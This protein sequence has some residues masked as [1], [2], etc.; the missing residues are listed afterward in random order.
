[1]GLDLTITIDDKGTPVIKSF[2]D[3][4]KDA[5]KDVEGQTKK[6]SDTIKSRWARAENAF[7]SNLGK[8]N[9]KE[10]IALKKIL[11]CSPLW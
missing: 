2:K 8:K 5:L 10:L 6:T 1:M 11:N 4:I 3:N 7:R 9:I